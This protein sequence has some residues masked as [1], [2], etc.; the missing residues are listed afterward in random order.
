M[1]L[2]L[3]LKLAFYARPTK[4]FVLYHPDYLLFPRISNTIPL[5]I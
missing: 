2:I 1:G 5:F 4:L 3:I